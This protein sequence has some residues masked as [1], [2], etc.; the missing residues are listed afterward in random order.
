MKRILMFSLA[1]GSVTLA[2]ACGDDDTVSVGPRAELTIVGDDPVQLPEA[3]FE[4]DYL[5]TVTA[6]GGTQR[7]ITW[8]L[9]DEDQLPTGL[10][11]TT[12]AN[13]LSISGRPRVTG[14]FNFR[15]QVTDSAGTATVKSFNL[16]VVE[17]PPELE[18]ITDSNPPAA[19]LD[20]PYGEFAFEAE[21]G[22]GTGYVFSADPNLLPPG[23]II[24]SDGVLSGTPT[25]VGNYQFV[26]QVRDSLGDRA[27]AN[28]ALEVVS[29]GEPFELL[30]ENCPDGKADEP[31]E[32]EFQMQGGVMPYD[33]QVGAGGGLPPGLELVQPGPMDFTG[34][35]R[36]VPTQPGNYAFQIRADDSD[37]ATER[38]SF[39]VFIDEADAPL[40]VTGR[41]LYPDEPDENG[42]PTERFSF[43][44][45]EVSK[46]TNTEIVAIGG[47]ESG[48]AWEKVSGDFPPGCSFTSSTPN[49]L[50]TCNPTRPGCF[51]FELRVVDSDGEASVPREFT[52]CVRPE[53][54]PLT[55]PSATG[56]PNVTML[57]DAVLD[58][59][60]TVSIEAAGGLPPAQG[61]GWTVTPRDGLP[62][63][64]TIFRN[65]DPA[66]AIQGTATATGTYDFNITVY[67]V[68]QRNT[69]APFRIE[70]VTST[71]P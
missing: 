37:R 22:S 65:G 23:M 21:G 19:A 45:F 68:E 42:D 6:T 25:R 52:L 51:V 34:F 53:V 54:L 1:V 14:D 36:G 67:D 55:I 5:A 15:L 40:R 33:L 60:Y 69:T 71:V 2:A 31:Y 9:L 3:T 10:Y 46:V 50:L 41:I 13:P 24:S 38:Q 30:T 57:P 16:T 56:L 63:G 49:A 7:L 12:Q 35:L 11:I 64:L 4:E 28:F 62:P 59:S 26:L 39:F 47:S 27:Q 58:E 44:G 70:V 66:T 8:T 20:Q 32:C 43:E 17:G 48:Y 29:V 18:I 61:Y